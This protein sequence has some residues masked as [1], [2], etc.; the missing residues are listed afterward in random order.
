MKAPSPGA[1]GLSSSVKDS[2]H[3]ITNL[4][5]AILKLLIAITQHINT[6]EA[7]SQ[8]KA[9]S[10]GA[11]LRSEVER[12]SI[13]GFDMSVG[14]GRLDAFLSHSPKTRE[15]LI[16]TCLD[17]AY[18]LL[19]AVH[20]S[21]QSSERCQDS[22]RALINTLCHIR[23]IEPE[24]VAEDVCSEADWDQCDSYDLEDLPDE[25]NAHIVCLLDISMAI[26]DR[27][28][29]PVYGLAGSPNEPTGHSP[30]PSING[31]N[32]RIDSS[33]DSSIPAG[34]SPLV[35]NPTWHFLGQTTERSTDTE[36]SQARRCVVQRISA[37]RESLKALHDDEVTVESKARGV[38]RASN[39]PRRPSSKSPPAL[40]VKGIR[41]HG[42][43]RE[44]NAVQETITH[45]A[46][47]LLRRPTKVSLPLSIAIGAASCLDALT[48]RRCSY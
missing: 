30:D 45:R 24:L 21:L 19:T 10:L 35:R 34:R 2:Y 32:I 8:N 12:L 41:T 28:G 22:S 6:T 47:A 7:G 5:D 4:F 44:Q 48:A 9:P 26:G 13:W 20:Q 43:S 27:F 16:T 23:S 18:L 40:L 1:S 39:H 33:A 37:L 25:I 11:S 29:E 42:G 46:I 14:G 15:A 38:H 3:I 31:D 36:E 17:L